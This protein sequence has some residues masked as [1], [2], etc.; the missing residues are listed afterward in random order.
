MVTKLSRPAW[1]DAPQ[2]R[3]DPDPTGLVFMLAQP[4]HPKSLPWVMRARSL[5]TQAGSVGMSSEYDAATRSN[6]LVILVDSV[7]AGTKV[8]RAM[9]SLLKEEMAETI[10]KTFH[11]QA[12]VADFSYE[13]RLRDQSY[14]GLR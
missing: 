11:P 14:R 9:S 2:S 5:L 1:V 3:N 10:V 4:N 12:E 6:Q 8:R 7:Q 13:V